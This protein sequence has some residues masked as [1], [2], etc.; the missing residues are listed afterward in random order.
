[1]KILTKAKERGEFTIPD[2]YEVD[3]DAMY[4]RGPV[5]KFPNEKVY[6]LKGFTGKINPEHS[7]IHSGIQRIY[8]RI[9]SKAKP[10]NVERNRIELSSDLIRDNRE[11]RITEFLVAIEALVQEDSRTVDEILNQY[12]IDSKHGLDWGFD[13]FWEVLKVP[14][15]VAEEIGGYDAIS[16]LLESQ[17]LNKPHHSEEGPDNT[18]GIRFEL[19][20]N[21]KDRKIIIQKIANAIET[22]YDSKLASQQTTEAASLTR[23]AVSPVRSLFH[24]LF[25]K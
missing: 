1:M 8:Q 7:P 24:R 3:M 18:L 21:N 20:G 25:G 14:N 9:F 19:T 22:A 10:F 2:G 15:Q 6:L 11:N 23:E 13:E 4:R 5:I 17:N 12:E 16:S